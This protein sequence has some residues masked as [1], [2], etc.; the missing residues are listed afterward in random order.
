MPVLPFPVGIGA[1]GPKEFLW[2][3]VLPM[4]YH[5]ISTALREYVGYIAYRLLY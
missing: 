1:R 4:D 5:D 3:D 2:T